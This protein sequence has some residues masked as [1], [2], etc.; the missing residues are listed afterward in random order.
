[1]HSK[2]KKELDNS[3]LKLKF[4]SALFVLTLHFFFFLF[5]I[6]KS[7]VTPLHS[8]AGM[9]IKFIQRSSLEP[10]SLQHIKDNIVAGKERDMPLASKRASGKPKKSN[11][12]N[13]PP[14]APIH[15]TEEYSTAPT[16]H[17]PDQLILTLPTDPLKGNQSGDN[18]DF[19]P[20]IMAHHTSEKTF[21]SGPERLHMRTNLPPREVI[22]MVSKFI[23]LWPPGYTIDPCIIRKEE[24]DS[25]RDAVSGSDRAQLEEALRKEN[26][27]CR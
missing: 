27:V 25:L 12:A 9:K 19:A 18:I 24:V 26:Q 10:S 22:A 4:I 15:E 20:K 17:S 3:N 8:Q 14:P 2:S 23:G 21:S 5:L 7:A 1:M 13:V 11:N 6:S 16:A